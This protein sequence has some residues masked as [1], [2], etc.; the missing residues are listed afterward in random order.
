MKFVTEIGYQ[1]GSMREF[2]YGDPL[3]FVFD[4]FIS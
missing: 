1:V 2:R 3:G 4:V